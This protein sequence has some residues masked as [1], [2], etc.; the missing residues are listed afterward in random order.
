MVGAIRKS[1]KPNALSDAPSG[2]LQEPLRTHILK[3]LDQAKKRV[4]QVEM[5]ATLETGFS[6]DARNGEVETLEATKKSTE[7]LKADKIRKLEASLKAWTEEELA[8]PGLSCKG[9]QMF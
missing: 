8:V 4:D 6:V 5:S 7:Q 1:W 3:L 2:K 9:N